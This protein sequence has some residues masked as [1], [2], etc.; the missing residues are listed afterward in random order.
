VDSILFNVVAFA[1]SGF[2]PPFVLL[3]VIGGEIV[4]KF[5]VA[6]LWAIGGPR[7]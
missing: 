4:A 7:R 2:F 6:A 1:G 3:K 5:V